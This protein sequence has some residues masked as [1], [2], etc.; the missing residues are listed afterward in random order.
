MGK[1]AR[2]TAAKKAK[3]FASDPIRFFVT[4][5]GAMQ[6]YASDDMQVV[7]YPHG[8]KRT[9]IA[10]AVFDGVLLAASHYYDGAVR[11]SICPQIEGDEVKP[12]PNMDIHLPPKVQLRWSDNTPDRLAE[13]VLLILD[14]EPHPFGWIDIDASGDD[15]IERQV[16]Y[17]GT[18]GNA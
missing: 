9:E 6:A 1:L 5:W 10:K 7:A 18:R 13:A 4:V 15:K 11:V 14:V 8:L 12:G 3:E 17:I 2:I 16:A